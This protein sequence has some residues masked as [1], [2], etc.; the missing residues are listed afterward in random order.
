MSII[1]ILIGHDLAYRSYAGF[2]GSGVDV[3][4]SST[5]H[6]WYSHLV[7]IVLALTTLGIFTALASSKSFSLKTLIFAQLSGFTVLEFSE[8]IIFNGSFSNFV[9]IVATGLVFQVLI[10]LPIYLLTSLL[11]EFKNSFVSFNLDSVSKVF[12][13]PSMFTEILVRV[14]IFNHSSPGRAPPLSVVK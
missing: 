2:S 7:P 5:G 3:V 11:F 6:N 1:G 13:L 8:R 14:K 4:L 12:K 10:S 9:F